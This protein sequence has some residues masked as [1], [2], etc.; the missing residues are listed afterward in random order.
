MVAA[1]QV[2]VRHGACDVAVH[3]LVDGRRQRVIDTAHLAGV[4][5]DAG[6]PVCA[7]PAL[8]DDP[9]PPPLPALPRPLAEYEALTGGAF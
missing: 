5:C 7:T 3:Q 2:R 6:R 1:G 9:E 8:P 4:A